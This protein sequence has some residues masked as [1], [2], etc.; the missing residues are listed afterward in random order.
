MQGN[1]APNRKKKERKTGDLVVQKKSLMEKRN[2]KIQKW[3]GSL[4]TKVYENLLFQYVLTCI[5]V[6]T[7]LQWNVLKW[8][9]ALI[10]C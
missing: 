8:V 3:Q 6:P 1:T 7:T 5:Q 9:Y 10:N 2:K 4:L